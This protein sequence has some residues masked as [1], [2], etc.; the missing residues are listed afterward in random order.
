[1]QKFSII[2]IVFA[3]SVINVLLVILAILGSVLTARVLGPS[4]RGELAAVQLWPA[5]LATFG[6]LGLTNA[7][8]YYCGRYPERAA[9]TFATACAMLAVLAVPLMLIGYAIL[10]VAFARQRPEALSAARAMLLII[11]MQ[12]VGNLPYFALQGL[13]EFRTWNVVRALFSALWLA[14]LIFARW[15]RHATVWFLAWGYLAAF[16]IICAVWLATMFRTVPGAYR[17]AYG[18]T[19]PLLKYGLPTVAASA[20]QQVNLRLDQALM[21]FFLAPNVLG[22]YTVSVAVGGLPS[23]FLTAISQAILPYLSQRGG[24]PGQAPAAARALRI[25]TAVALVVTAACMAATPFMLPV[26]YGDAFR[27]ALPAAIILVAGGGLIGLN[28]IAAETLKGMGLPKLPLFA[29]LTGALATVALLP[30]LLWRYGMV[31]AAAASIVS[32]FITWITYVNLFSKHTGI[33]IRECI[34]PTFAEVRITLY[35]LRQQRP[36]FADL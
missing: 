13:G 22:L 21:A 17:P 5:Y 12:L 1:M 29:E 27:P 19:R 14:V 36:S 15:S 20:P 32:Y 26:F 16:G 33:P 2:R 6:S 31:G 28:T 9:S 3:G 11:P 8:A 18:M 10:P 35:G 24:D 30:V 4:G 23:P 34:F 25:S 7:T